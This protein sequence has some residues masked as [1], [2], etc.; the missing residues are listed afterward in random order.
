MAKN[1]Q[2]RI[3]ELEG[4]IDLHLSPGV[5]QELQALVKQQPKKLIVDLTRVTYMDSSGLA[6]LLEGMQSVE[7][8]RGKFCLIGV[9]DPLRTV[10]ESSRLDQVFRIYPD[11]KTALA[12]G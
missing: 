5:A 6:V 8:Y 1:E 7:S 9:G 3:L 4:E 11:L 2:H 12:T 10:F